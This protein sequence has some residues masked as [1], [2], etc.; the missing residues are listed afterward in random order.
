MRNALDQSIEEIPETAPSHHENIEAH[1]ESCWRGVVVGEWRA[2]NL[3]AGWGLD[4]FFPKP[5][6]QRFVRFCSS[7]SRYHTRPL[8]PS[9]SKI[10]VHHRTSTNCSAR[11]LYTS[12]PDHQIFKGDVVDI[13]L[14]ALA[15]VRLVGLDREG[16][17]SG[18]VA[19]ADLRG[20]GVTSTSTALIL[21]RD[22]LA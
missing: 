18:G 7:P 16:R 9:R 8:V 4:A 14:K 11:L 22:R 15:R 10:D 17:C 12:T 3:E 13:R 1:R 21:Y 5:N 6:C 19:G 2:E 20:L